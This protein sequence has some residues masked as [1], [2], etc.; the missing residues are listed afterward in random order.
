MKLKLLIFLL[1]ASLCGCSQDAS[2]DVPAPT[3]MSPDTGVDDA[4]T[5]DVGPDLSPQPR[6]Y[7]E[8][9]AWPANSGP[10]L[11][12][13]NFAPEEVDEHCAYID[14]GED[15]EFKHNL[16]V[17]W[18]G[19]LVM[20]WAPDLG[21][22]GLSFFD[23]SEPCNPQR[24]GTAFDKNMRET[25][26]LPIFEWQDRVYATTA[27]IFDLITGG[28]LIWDVTD[29]TD[30]RRVANFDV[31]GFVFPDAY[32]KV[33]FST[34]W[35]PPYLFV[36]MAQLGVVVLDLTDPMN[37]EEVERYTF[38]PVAQI[39][40][41]QVIGNLVVATTSEGPR[42]ILL[43]AS[44]PLDLQPIPGGDYLSV[45]ADGTPREA[46]FTTTSNGFV[47]YARKEGG[48]GLMIYDI[49]D[50]E[51]PVKTGGIQ[52]DGNGGYV[53][54]QNDLAFVGLGDHATIF[55]ISDHANITEVKRLNLTGDLDT[56]TPIGNLA[57]LAVDDG[58]INRQA[59][60]IVPY[61]SEPDTRAPTVTWSWPKDGAENLARGSRIGFTFDEFV[62][63]RSAWEGSVRVYE[64]DSDPAVTRV[65]GWIAAQETIV[66]FT[67]VEALKPNTTYVLDVP[68]GGITDYAGNATVER[69]SIE[70]TTGS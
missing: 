15:D 64:K 67:P 33:T 43:D 37:P 19:Y 44:D 5:S 11:G 10:G 14:G 2:S 53:F 23:V 24:I 62:D 57:V 18:D 21:Q 51:N 41:V 42:T 3:D 38:E 9:A 60:A 68:A 46:Y 35:Q 8:A 50:P 1:V 16:V 29:P 59:T 27:S 56:V 54:V 63:P 28:V 7:P 66:N 36:G 52:T 39:G 48:G 61:Q 20:P 69:F 13:V 58:S 70:F 47:Y 4:D 22:G 31:D 17:M 34:F 32:K 6:P 25:H 49:R 45:D 40:Q 55:D 65:D 26:T 12:S 30:M